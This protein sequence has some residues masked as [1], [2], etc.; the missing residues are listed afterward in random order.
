MI[1]Y[2]YDSLIK[3]KI[4]GE[5]SKIKIYFFVF[6]NDEIYMFPLR[7]NKNISI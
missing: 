1:L 2:R 7:I 4:T 3:S 6:Q 5:I